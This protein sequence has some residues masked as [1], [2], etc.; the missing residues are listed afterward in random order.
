MSV[1]ISYPI[2]TVR[3]RAQQNQYV[4]DEKTKKYAGTF[5][6]IKRTYRDEGLLGFF[7]GFF[8]GPLVIQR[9][10]IVSPVSSQRKQRPIFKAH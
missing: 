9:E 10:G 6:I 2:T 7:K 4:I 8:G 5:E 3:T 1:L